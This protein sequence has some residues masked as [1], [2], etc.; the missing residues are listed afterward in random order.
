MKR[1][2]IMVVGLLLLLGC[3]VILIKDRINESLNC[4]GLVMHCAAGLQKPMQEIAR[5]FEEE[6]GIPVHLNFGG[7][8]QLYSQLELVGGDVYFPADMSYIEKGKGEGLI[9]EAI[10]LITLV[11]E[12][13]V[14]EGNP[15]EI[16]SLVDLTRGDVRV[17]IAD[18]SAAVGLF[19]HEVLE[20]A[21]LLERMEMGDLA[22]MGTVNEVALQINIGAADVGIVWNV[23]G[24]QFEDCE[25]ISVNEFEELPKCAGFGRVV[26]SKRP[27]ETSTFFTYLV[28]PGKGAKIFRKYGF[29]AIG[30]APK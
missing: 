19:T 22:K 16:H 8:G 17:V 26:N 30:S 29:G 27:E 24:S 2:G 9:D 11:A 21:G 23:L 10:P 18:R 13:I 14:A 5:G 6:T 4:P 28:S 3:L 25:F 1:M 7:S 12:L 15:K 20:K